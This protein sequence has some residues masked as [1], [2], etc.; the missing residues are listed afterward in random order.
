MDC[1]ASP[2]IY[3]APLAMTKKQHPLL[4]RR[5]KGEVNGFS[6][7]NYFLNPFLYS[8]LTTNTCAHQGLIRYA[9]RRYL[10]VAIC[11][12]CSIPKL[13]IIRSH[14]KNDL[15]VF[16]FITFSLISS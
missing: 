1:R 2:V 9:S 7:T 8:Y 15:S 5:G 16:S 13:S 3:L 10:V 11:P 4:P 12:C 6:L 14:S